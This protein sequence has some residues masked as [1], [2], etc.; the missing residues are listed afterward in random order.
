[1]L[2]ILTARMYRA[3]NIHVII[4]TIQQLLTGDARHVYRDL[5]SLKAFFALIVRFIGVSRLLSI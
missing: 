4:K 1:M 5:Y 3:N 2:A